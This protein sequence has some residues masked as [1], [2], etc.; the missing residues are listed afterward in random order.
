MCSEPDIVAMSVAEEHKEVRRRIVD[1]LEKIIR[2]AG[3]DMSKVN[4][5]KKL[6]GR[7]RLDYVICLQKEAEYSEA[8]KVVEEAKEGLEDEVRK[9]QGSPSKGANAGND[10]KM[11]RFDLAEAIERKGLILYEKRGMIEATKCFDQVLK[12]RQE[13]S[14]M[15]PTDADGLAIAETLI[16]Q[17]RVLF[18]SNRIEEAMAKY[19]EAFDLR[20]RCKGDVTLEM[21]KLYQ[22]RSALKLAQDD[23]DGSLQDLA[24]SMKIICKLLGPD[25][26]VAADVWNLMGNTYKKKKDKQVSAALPIFIH[27]FDCPVHLAHHLARTATADHRAIFCCAQSL[28]EAKKYYEKSLETKKRVSGHNHPSVARTLTNLAGHYYK[29]HKQAQK[30]VDL[31]ENALAINI[32]KY[33]E[34]SPHCKNILEEIAK[35]WK[36]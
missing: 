3:D 7:A 11:L 12:M 10:F 28:L 14:S 4:P 1:L 19:E 31:F 16:N 2:D 18:R 25:N 15:P 34:K 24:E 13:M 9:A 8:L 5:P 36:K 22:H 20:V 32:D 33:G 29:D 30:A 23:T 21:A 27:C 26:I 17:G 35:I 6:V